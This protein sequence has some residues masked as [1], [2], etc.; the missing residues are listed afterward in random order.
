MAH[1][2]TPVDIPGIVKDFQKIV[3]DL[4]ESD[5]INRSLSYAH[6]VADVI[7][8][9]C[10]DAA[11]RHIPGQ[12]I[13]EHKKNR[14]RQLR[15]LDNENRQLRQLY[16]DSQWTLHLV[17]EAHRRLMEATFGKDNDLASTRKQNEEEE[18]NTKQEF[19]V[20]AARMT[21]AVHDIFEH[22]KEMSDKIQKRVEELRVE[23]D[24]LRCILDSESGAD[25]Q[26]IY[27]RLENK[28]PKHS[29]RSSQ[30][31]FGRYAHGDGAS[32]DRDEEATPRKKASVILN[33]SN[34]DVEDRTGIF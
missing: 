16:E 4:K 6:R 5:K 9:R 33:P 2:I 31:D 25:I 29:P 20:N 30:D 10:G 14:N 13:E 32:R 23:N 12:D 19:Y 18:E 24:I 27:D 22:E 8:R 21:K 7:Q 11:V 34:G 3:V 28:T 15:D 17:M 1:L 26:S